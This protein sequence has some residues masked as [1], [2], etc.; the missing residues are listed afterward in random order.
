MA[1]NDA[2]LSLL[3]SASGISVVPWLAEHADHLSSAP[4]F[5]RLKLVYCGD[6]F[7]SNDG[8][9][10]VMFE[11]VNLGDVRRLRIFWFRAVQLAKY[12]FDRRPF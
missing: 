11:W 4:R 2:L 6:A 12:Q 9:Y 1:E 3:P 5:C 7:A 8:R 10:V